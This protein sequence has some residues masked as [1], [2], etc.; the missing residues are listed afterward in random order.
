MQSNQILNPYLVDD[1]P[2]VR[3]VING[4]TFDSRDY[5][6]M[7]DVLTLGD[8]FS[9]IIPNLDG[10]L[11]DAFH[12]GDPLDLYIAD[13]LVDGGA[14]IKQL[15]GLVV[16]KDLIS[17]KSQGDFI[18]VSGADIGWHLQNNTVKPW[19]R[20]ANK[21]LEFLYTA[22]VD[23][24]WGFTGFQF[25]NSNA[26]LKLGRAAVVLQIGQEN[27]AYPNFLPHIQTEPGEI[28]ADLFIKYAKFSKALVNVSPTGMLQFWTPN[29]KSKPAYEF[30]YHPTNSKSV[31]SNNVI[32]VNFSENLQNIY[33]DASCFST[34]VKPI[35]YTTNNQNEGHYHREA[36]RSRSFK[37]IHRISFADGEQM[38]DKDVQRR[39]EW[40]LNR[41]EFDSWSYTVTVQGHNQNGIPYTPDT[42]CTIKDTVNKVNGTF[43]VSS[44]KLERTKE[45]G[46][47][48]TLTIRKPKLLEP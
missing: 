12:V 18:R 37:F 32:T 45:N 48:T 21:K 26:P 1:T 20:L 10:Y 15:K 2:I 28:T 23:S 46:T 13:P 30:N 41:S 9:C 31:G 33:T 8:P 16:I 34:L 43:Y 29:Y 47:R 7:S 24:S 4:K 11:S 27:N 3:L 38:G 40:K 35:V 42:M 14:E 17:D 5:M 22:F 44:V 36:K 6:I 19:Q 39:A 25:R